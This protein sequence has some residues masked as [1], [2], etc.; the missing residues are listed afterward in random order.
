MTIG[1]RTFLSGAATGVGLLVLAGCTPPR[2]TPTRSVTQAPVP[3]PSTTA[4]PT[5]A[6]FV[7]SAWGADPYALGSTS[8]LP[9][10]A[11]PEHREDLAQNVLDRVF[12]AG[13]ATDSSAP[14]TLQGA[15]N[16][17]VRA[18]GEIA[19]IAADGERIAI[20]GAGL[21]GAVAARRLVDV[22]NTGTVAV[23]ALQLESSAPVVGAS[24]SDGLQIALDRCSQP[25]STDGATCGG[26]ITPIAPDRPATARIDLP[27]SPAFAVGATDHLRLTL[28]LPE[29]SP[30]AAQGTTGSI[31]LT[32]IGVQRP[33]RHL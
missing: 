5:P 7:R 28:R 16:S 3:T 10:G 30:T 12:F 33:G 9:V 6:A 11:T 21:A 14:G 24:S 4:V 8:Y 20:I 25:W 2:P 29:S 15:W 13:E 22:T 19:A 17:G 23:A 1:R 27:A 26:T 32:V 31:A 18:A